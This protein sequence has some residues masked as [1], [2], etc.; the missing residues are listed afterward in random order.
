MKI[1][2]ITKSDVDEKCKIDLFFTIIF[3]VR[4]V[5]LYKKK[6]K[7]YLLNSRNRNKNCFQVYV[8]NV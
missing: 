8:F 3:F 5:A 7:Q 4:F 2:D 6:K 1:D